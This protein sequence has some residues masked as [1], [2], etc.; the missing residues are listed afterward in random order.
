MLYLY[1]TIPFDLNMFG[2]IQALV[3]SYTTYPTLFGSGSQ[4]R[5]QCPIY[6]YGPYFEVWIQ[7]EFMILKLS[8]NLKRSFFFVV[9]K[10]TLWDKE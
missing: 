3:F 10:V 1:D 7:C 5:F 6:A 2:Y 9:P 8:I 4:M